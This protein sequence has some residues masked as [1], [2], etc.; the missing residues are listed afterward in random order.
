M[1]LEVPSELCLLGFFLNVASNKLIS[2]YISLMYELGTIPVQMCLIET[3]LHSSAS[4]ASSMIVVARSSS[5]IMPCLE[6]SN[7]RM[8]DSLGVRFSVLLRIGMRSRELLTQS[9]IA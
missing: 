4:F 5:D 2:V 6:C 1:L 3:F 7:S 8:Y 9:S